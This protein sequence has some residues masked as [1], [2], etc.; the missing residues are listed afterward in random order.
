MK[1]AGRMGPNTEDGFSN[2]RMATIRAARCFRNADT[3][4]IVA[5]REL[6]IE[7]YDL[8]QRAERK[9]KYQTIASLLKLRANLFTRKKPRG[10]TSAS[11]ERRS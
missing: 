11:Q 4:R 8:K 10:R 9:R 1:H 2:D 6:R 7:E 3:L 5:N